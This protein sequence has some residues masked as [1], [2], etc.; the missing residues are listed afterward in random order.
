MPRRHKAQG[1]GHRGASRSSPEGTEVQAEACQRSENIRETKLNA[2]TKWWGDYH[3]GGG[4]HGL[5]NN[6]T[7]ETNR[8]QNGG[9]KMTPRVENRRCEQTRQR[10]NRVAGSVRGEP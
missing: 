1:R 7:V 6:A 9:R 8:G 5:G 4:T 2:Y 10:C 3:E